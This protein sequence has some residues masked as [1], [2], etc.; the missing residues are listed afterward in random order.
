MKTKQMITQQKIS[1]SIVA[2][3]I[4]ASIGIWCTGLMDSV[5]VNADL[6][7]EQ[8]LLSMHLRNNAADLV[9]QRMLAEAYWRRYEDIRSDPFYGENGPNGIFGARDHYRHHGKIEG[10]IFGPI[11]AVADLARE[12]ALADAYWQRYPDI[13]ESEVWGRTGSLGVLGP[14]DHFRYVGKYQGKTWGESDT[15]QN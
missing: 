4:A 12:Q 14:R 8:Q 7:A 13:A 1:F 10:R 9:E 11:A 5:V 15:A 6:R 2:A 3:T